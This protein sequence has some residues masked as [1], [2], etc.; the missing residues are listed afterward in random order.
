MWGEIAQAHNVDEG[1]GARCCL[2]ELKYA[3]Y[4]VY[5]RVAS[6]KKKL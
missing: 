4:S 5:D 3:A 6:M 1:L 2:S